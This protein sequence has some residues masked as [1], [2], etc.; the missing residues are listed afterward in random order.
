[1]QTTTQ[2]VNLFDPRGGSLMSSICEEC[3]EPLEPGSLLSTC[4]ECNRMAAEEENFS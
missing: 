2:S 1:M 3:N 4:A